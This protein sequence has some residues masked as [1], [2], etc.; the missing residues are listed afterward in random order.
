[1]AA[2]VSLLSFGGESWGSHQWPAKTGFSA[3]YKAHPVIM[4]LLVLI[5]S[6]P[7]S[8]LKPSLMTISSPASY[9]LCCSGTYGF[10]ES[11]PEV[12]H[13]NLFLGETF[14]ATGTGQAQLVIQ[15][16]IM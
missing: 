6:F 4:Y 13:V 11:L 2:L 5:L 9:E 8:S 3:I 15:F 1:M 12:P 7:S 10:V 14:G 16:A